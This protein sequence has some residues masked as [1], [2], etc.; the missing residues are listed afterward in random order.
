MALP[1]SVEKP[2]EAPEEPGIGSEGHLSIPSISKVSYVCPEVPDTC[3][4]P[5]SS[6]ISSV[7]GSSC[8]L[9]TYPKSSSLSWQLPSE[10]CFIYFLSVCVY[11]HECVGAFGGQKTLS[12]AIHLFFFF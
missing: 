10:M 12:K 5:S 6:W 11:V 1:A 4:L 9:A 3:Q 8:H 2:E 7:V